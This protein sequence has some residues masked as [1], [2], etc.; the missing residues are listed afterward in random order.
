MLTHVLVHP[1]TANPWRMRT[2]NFECL[3]GSLAKFTMKV[4]QLIMYL[5][6]QALPV[7]GASSEP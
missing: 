1:S 3:R 4:N 2:L 7:L 6:T 5:S